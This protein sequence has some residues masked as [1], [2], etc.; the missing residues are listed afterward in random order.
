MSSEKSD[1][2]VIRQ[3]DFSESSRVLTLFT[4]DFGK[5]SCLAKGVKRLKTAFEGSL[6]LLSECSVELGRCNL[7]LC[8]DCADRDG[9]ASSAGWEIRAWQFDEKEEW[10]SWIVWQAGVLLAPGTT[11]FTAEV[12]ALLRGTILLRQFVGRMR[13]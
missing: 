3:A 8:T 6:D 5:I 4:R 10:T 2:I 13:L 1:A 9:Q 7:I 12:A 11:A